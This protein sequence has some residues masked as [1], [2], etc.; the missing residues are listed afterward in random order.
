MDERTGDLILTAASIVDPKLG[1]EFTGTLDDAL[2]ALLAYA[3]DRSA[4]GA[5]ISRRFASSQHDRIAEMLAAA[6]LRLAAMQD[7]SADNRSA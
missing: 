7:R 4:I 2:D 5:H 1:E 6:L 3:A